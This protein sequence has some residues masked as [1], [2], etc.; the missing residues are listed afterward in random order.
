MGC[1]SSKG[2][3]P[4]PPLGQLD[5][6]SVDP[7]IGACTAEEAMEVLALGY[8]GTATAPAEEVTSWI[9]GSRFA[10]HD[11][12]ERASYMQ[13]CAKFMVLS[14]TKKGTVLGL[15]DAATQQVL[16]VVALRRTPES[17]GE[18][19]RTMMAAG[20]PPHS[21][22]AK[23]G[24]EPMKR[25]EAAIKAMKRLN[26]KGP[27]IIIYAIAVR[28]EHQGQKIATAL[29]NCAFALGDR[30]GVPVTVQCGGSTSDDPGRVEQMYAHLGFERESAVDTA[31][32]EPP[33]G[34]VAMVRTPKE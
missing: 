10:A 9:I 28:P 33:L 23:Y 20:N 34:L 2:V 16:G 22:T 29:V 30:D 18:I 17:D 32:G 8:S 15:R 6:L 27:Q 31:P 14:A 21:K 19:M 12:P 7:R 1:G 13:Y 11:S 4:G 25:D 26:H 24:K 5:G 3:A